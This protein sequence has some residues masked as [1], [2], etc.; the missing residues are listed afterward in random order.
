M[1]NVMIDLETFGVRPGSVILSIGAVRFC[2]QSGELGQTF[3]QTISLAS[4]LQY[5]LTIDPSTVA[6]W[7]KQSEAAQVVLKAAAG[8]AAQDLPVVFAEFSAWLRSGPSKPLIWGCGANFDNVLLRAAYERCDLRAPW[9]PFD[10]RCFR[11]LKDGNADLEP[12]REGV[13]HDA[14]D[15]ALHQARWALASAAGRRTALPVAETA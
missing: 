10:D 8:S 7:L 12:K 2:P 15:D 5:G 9:S 11:T 1:R 4:C 3:H 6:W 13:H 14:L